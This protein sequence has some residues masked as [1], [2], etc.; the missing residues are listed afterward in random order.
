MKTRTKFTAQLSNVEDLITRLGSK[1]GDDIRATG[2]AVSGDRGAAQGVMKGR[3]SEDRLRTGIEEECLDIMLLQQ[4][5][6]GDDLRFVT[7]SFRIVSDLTHIDGMTRDICFI[8][9]ETKFEA[10][11]KFLSTIVELSEKTA[12]M[13]EDATTSFLE[14]DLD[15]ANAVIS[16][17]EEVNALYDSAEDRVVKFIRKE[18]VPA[19]ELPN[20]LMV[21]KYYERIG[22]LAKRIATWTI[23]R[24]TGERP[25]S[26]DFPYYD[27]APEERDDEVA[28]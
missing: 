5:L 17:D 7:G 15:A 1:C 27:G 18:S 13:V 22:D 25:L 19:G 4:P 10:S 28:E 3:K 23:F 12:K 14:K 16:A 24:V 6:I 21:A 2:L 8:V 9:L 26:S 20:L 11:E